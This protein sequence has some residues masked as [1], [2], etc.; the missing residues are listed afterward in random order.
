MDYEQSRNSVKF[1]EILQNSVIVRNL[2]KL[3]KVVSNG[4]LVPF[5]FLK[6]NVIIS[7]SD[8]IDVIVLHLTLSSRYFGLFDFQL[9]HLPGSAVFLQLK[10][11]AA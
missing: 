2:R 5:S 8:N 7:F 3:K 6:K 10:F 4:E 11:P 9:T 1:C